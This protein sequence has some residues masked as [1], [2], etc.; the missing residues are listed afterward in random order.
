[1]LDSADRIWNEETFACVIA[2]S[3]SSSMERLMLAGTTFSG[4]W[5]TRAGA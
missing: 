4:R 1:V 5:A 3:C 2:R